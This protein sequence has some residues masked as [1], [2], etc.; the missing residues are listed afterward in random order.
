MWVLVGWQASALPFFS[1][2]EATDDP[3]NSNY[4]HPTSPPN[5]TKKKKQRSKPP[6]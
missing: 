3:T 6:D 5:K 4:I 1:F 2:G